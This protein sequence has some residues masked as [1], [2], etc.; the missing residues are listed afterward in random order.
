MII[1]VT[2]SSGHAACPGH[3][4]G[5]GTE[6]DVQVTVGDPG[7]GVCVHIYIGIFRHLNKEYE[8]HFCFR[9]S[10]KVS[11]KIGKKR[12]KISD[13]STPKPP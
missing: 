1:K 3:T 10:F 9:I 7:Y 11:P 12:H 5:L 6:R 13:P 2:A 4:G 8:S